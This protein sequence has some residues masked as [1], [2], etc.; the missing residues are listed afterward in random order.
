MCQRGNSLWFVP[1]RGKSKSGSTI[2]VKQHCYLVL[3]Q[4]FMLRQ[5]SAASDTY[6]QQDAGAGVGKRKGQTVHTF[7]AALI[8]WAGYDMRNAGLLQ[9]ASNGV[10]T[11]LT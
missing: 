6:L 4:R 9:A 11:I 7:A 10:S 3:K 8:W 5:G 2:V 1:A